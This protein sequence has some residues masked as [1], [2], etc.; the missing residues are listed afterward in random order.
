M[1]CVEYRQPGQW[2]D[3]VSVHV[4]YYVTDAVYADGMYDAVVC[5]DGVYDPSCTAYE[6]AQP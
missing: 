4:W 5:A 1:Q 2:S 6:R 3:S